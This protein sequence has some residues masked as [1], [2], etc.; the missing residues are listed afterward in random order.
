MPVAK[1][2]TQQLGSW[3]FL[4]DQSTGT[5]LGLIQQ[6]FISAVFVVISLGQ[7]V[8]IIVEKTDDAVARNIEFSAI[9]LISFIPFDINPMMV[10][11]K[12][13]IK[14]PADQKSR[15]IAEDVVQNAAQG[16]ITLNSL[17]Q[18]LKTALFDR[19]AKS[20]SHSCRRCGSYANDGRS[21][22][23][24]DSKRRKEFHP[25]RTLSLQGT[26]SLHITQKKKPPR[27]DAASVFA[28]ESIPQG[29]NAQ[30][31]QE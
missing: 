26:K 25:S 14:A 10:G 15:N 24:V 9:F 31:E 16:Y 19:R 28:G 8:N 22:I 17:V 20:H 1:Y 6:F 29:M 27:R 4:V 21:S 12:T 18:V 2:Q 13:K 5:C 3:V 11:K 23:N 7:V 30:E